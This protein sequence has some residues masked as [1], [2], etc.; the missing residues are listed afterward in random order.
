MTNSIEDLQE[1]TMAAGDEISHTDVTAVVP[2]VWGAEIESRAEKERIFRNYVKINTDL[3]G[4]PGD[5]V[6]LPK[7]AYIDSGSYAAA[8][9]SADTDDVS[10]NVELEFDTITATPTEVGIGARITKQ[11]IEEAMVSL[12]DDTIDNMAIGVALKEDADIVTALTAADDTNP[13]KYVEANAD[14]DTFVSG[15]WT[16]ANATGPFLNIDG[17]DVLDLSAIVEASEV[18]LHNEGFDADTLVI[19]PRQKASLLR[20]ANFLEANRAGST[21]SRKKGV[22]GTLFGLDVVTSRNLNTVTISGSATGYQ[23]IMLDSSAAG[24]LAVKRPVT[25]ETD[26]IPK[27]RMHYIFA[28]SMYKAERLNNKA[29]C[30]ILTA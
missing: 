29:I 20:D 17:D 12:L 15:D 8:D 26:Y 28:T 13:V 5:S 4:R 30:L 21:E 18:V 16:T 25:V 3:V 9:I 1:V 6:K 10:I 22:V 27:E 23:A 24:V 11:A 2:E 19:H 14:N 7:K